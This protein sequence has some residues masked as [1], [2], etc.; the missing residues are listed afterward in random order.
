M[1]ERTDGRMLDA[2]MYVRMDGYANVHVRVCRQ[3]QTYMQT[4]IGMKCPCLTRAVSAFLQAL[5][6]VTLSQ[7]QH[8]LTLRIE[9]LIPRPC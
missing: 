5:L 6:Q 2:C 8:L 3:L 7:T 9:R 4:G 1:A